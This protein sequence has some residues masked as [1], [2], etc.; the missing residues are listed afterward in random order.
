[1]KIYTSSSSLVLALAYMGNTITT[2][3]GFISSPTIVRRTSSHPTGFRNSPSSSSSEVSTVTADHTPHTTTPVHPQRAALSPEFEMARD[4]TIQMLS[5]AVES[6]RLKSLLSHFTEEYFSACYAANKAGVEEVTS[7][8]TAKSMMNALQYG[9]QFGVGENKYKFGVS[10]VALRG[11]NPESENGNTI[12]FY[13]FGCDF[14]RPAMDL[15]NSIVYG[16]ANLQKAQEQIQRGENVIFLANHQSDADP[17]VVSC[18]FEKAVFTQMAEDMYYV[19]GHKVTTDTLA[20]PF[21]M[22]RNL[23]CIHSKKHIDADPETK[24]LK[25]K[26]NLQAMSSMLELLKRGGTAIWVAPSGGRDRRALDGSRQVPLAPFDPKTVDMFRLM[27]T[28]SKKS[29]H[30]YAMSMVSYELCPPPD[31]IEAGTGEQRNVRFVPVGITISDELNNQNGSDGSR[32]EFTD[33]TFKICNDGYE[34]LLNGLKEG[35]SGVF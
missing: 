14:F 23:I 6:D 3:H 27:G 15:R 8:Y 34:K 29:T 4:A 24:P 18:L 21:S 20:V 9:M 5:K 10:H 7:K 31:Y 19:A 17:Q 12:D 16:Q 13:K 1:M 11:K 28:K 30:F 35:K 22:G 32:E 26:Q 2:V 33:I 25:S